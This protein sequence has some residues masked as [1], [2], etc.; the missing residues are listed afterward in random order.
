MKRPLQ[1]LAPVWGGAW[2]QKGCFVFSSSASLIDGFFFK[3]CTLGFIYIVYESTVLSI[4]GFNLPSVNQRYSD[5][6][7]GFLC[8]PFNGLALLK[9]MCVCLC[10]CPNDNKHDTDIAFFLFF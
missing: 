4:E 8:I 10:A 7:A 2:Q 5:S 6:A 1:F 3:A 9:R